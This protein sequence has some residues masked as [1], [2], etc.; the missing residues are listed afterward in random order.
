M[1]QI[2]LYSGLRPNKGN[3]PHFLPTSTR[4][5][6]LSSFS[7]YMHGEGYEEFY[8]DIN[9]YRINNGVLVLQASLLQT[10]PQDITYVL[11]TDGTAQ[12]VTYMRGYHVERY[13]EQSGNVIF[14]LSVDL[15][16]EG[17][18]ADI[19]RVHLT[20]CNKRIA[21]YAFYDEAQA[22]EALNALNTERVA[23]TF[24]P[25]QVSIVFLLNYN[26][27]QGLFNNEVIGRTELYAVTLQDCL[28]AANRTGLVLSGFTAVEVGLDIVGGVYGVNSN[29]GGNDAEVI[30]A[31]IVPTSW[32]T[33]G[34]IVLS[35]LK[36]RSMLTDG[37]GNVIPNV[38]NV[39]PHSVTGSFS[40][41]SWPR[42]NDFYP[43]LI[44][45]FGPRYNAFKMPRLCSYTNSPAVDYRVV[46]GQDDISVKLY[47]GEEEH[48]VSENF[49]VRLTTANNVANEL[50]AMAR[51]LS[52]GLKF[53]Q[54]ITAAYEKGGASAAGLSGLSSV[55]GNIK[56]AG[57]QTAKGSGD[58]FFSWNDGAER[59]AAHT[60]KHPFFYQFY[61]TAAD[62]RLRA[63]NY[64]VNIDFFG[65]GIGLFSTLNNN[66]FVEMPAA[67][68]NPTPYIFVQASE[69][70]LSAQG[71]AE[72]FIEDE[73]K[74]GI[75]L[76][77]V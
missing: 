62:E 14:Y 49:A 61:E 33:Y 6:F 1:R 23:E 43:N 17:I 19:G 10:L 64:G 48:D 29:T 13:I 39:I 20:K 16:L 21:R 36:V 68:L 47:Y 57:T 7:T 51:D 53:A 8:L 40:L 54:G 30:K 55:L 11:E 65:Y 12:N 18:F 38:R 72:A 2:T 26:V 59:S 46:I 5:A 58:G 74:R 35:G 76:L 63:R 44:V 4:E 52:F 9:N 42:W 22:V 69:I 66:A 3:N 37:S 27:S 34:D 67:T 73:F 56:P 24:T 75:Y 71:D 70:E 45:L 50:Q 60:I 41:S 15:W 31:W 77:V 28:D 32:L 25:S